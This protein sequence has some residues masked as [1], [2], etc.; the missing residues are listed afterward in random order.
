MLLRV[1]V[2]DGRAQET[3]GSL[4]GYEW[5]FKSGP[6]LLRKCSKSRG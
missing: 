3:M 1:R 4:E 6:G 5:P 2:N